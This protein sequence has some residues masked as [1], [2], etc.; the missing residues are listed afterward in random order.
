MF[1][2]LYFI[3]IYIQVLTSLHLSIYLFPLVVDNSDDD[4]YIPVKKSRVAK[5]VTGLYIILSFCEFFKM[6]P[7]D[8]NIYPFGCINVDDDKKSPLAN[9]MLPVTKEKKIPVYTAT[10]AIDLTGLYIAFIL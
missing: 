4:F 6:K 2:V 8:T 1:A 10:S 9:I 5:T 3:G 7:F